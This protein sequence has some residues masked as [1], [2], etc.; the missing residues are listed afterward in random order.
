MPFNFA[1]KQSTSDRI[2]QEAQE[3]RLAL[4]QLR[5][6]V[7]KLAEAQPVVATKVDR[8]LGGAW[9]KP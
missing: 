4:Q 5:A 9:K 3:D 8:L 6:D 1:I 2:Q 7:N